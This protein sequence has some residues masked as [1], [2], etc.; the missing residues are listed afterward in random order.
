MSNQTIKLREAAPADLDR[1]FEIERIAYQG[2]EAASREKISKRIAAYPEGFV[3][4]EMDGEVA[5][6]INSG[7]THDADLADDDFKELKGHDPDGPHVVVLSVAVHPDYQG[8]GYANLLMEHFVSKMKTLNKTS[9][10]LICQT[11]LIAMYSKQGF[12][13]S[14]ASASTHGGLKWHEMKMILLDPTP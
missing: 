7:A 14:G 9:I 12:H 8:R 2:H 11:S 4:L 5:G 1:C 6:F 3:V 13:Y 10:H